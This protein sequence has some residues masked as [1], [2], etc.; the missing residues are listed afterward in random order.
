MGITVVTHTVARGIKSEEMAQAKKKATSTLS[1]TEQ[2][3]CL[4]P[5][6]GE[7]EFCNRSILI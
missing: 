2:M 4:S 1:G 6:L 3:F 7:M 5:D